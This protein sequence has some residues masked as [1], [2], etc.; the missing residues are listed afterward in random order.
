MSKIHIQIG[1]KTFTTKKDIIEFLDVSPTTF[2]KYVK[3][4]A[5]DIN[6]AVSAIMDMKKAYEYKKHFV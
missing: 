4:N 6:K 5:G 3:E 2:S 1:E